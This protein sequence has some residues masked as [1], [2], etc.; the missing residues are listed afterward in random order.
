MMSCEV[1]SKRRA[2]ANSRSQKEGGHDGTGGKGGIKEDRQQA[3]AAAARLSAFEIFRSR[4][5]PEDQA[6][7]PDTHLRALLNLFCVF[8]F[9][10]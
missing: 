3:D 2:K 8:V 10:H 6:Y 5:E 4:T 7:L 9:A 1:C